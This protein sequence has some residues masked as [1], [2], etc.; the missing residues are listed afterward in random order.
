MSQE[1]EGDKAYFL[2]LSFAEEYLSIEEDDKQRMKHI[3]CC[4]SNFLA[5]VLV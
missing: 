1:I 2:L 3:K 5:A 4:L